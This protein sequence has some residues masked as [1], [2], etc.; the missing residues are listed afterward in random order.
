MSSENGANTDTS[1]SDVKK[2]Q[3]PKLK[4]MD[5]EL[6]TT[7]NQHRMKFRTLLKTI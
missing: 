7:P 6:L 3:H 1:T 2:E 4:T 5:Q